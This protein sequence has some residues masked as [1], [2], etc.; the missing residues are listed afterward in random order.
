MS[1]KPL[2]ELP[3]TKAAQID[4]ILGCLRLKT[5]TPTYIHRRLT[6]LAMPD[7]QVRE[8]AKA[9]FELHARRRE[10]YALRRAEGRK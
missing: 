4:Y 2:A 9:A 5:G 3:A 6:L 10:A 7:L 1:S 8:M